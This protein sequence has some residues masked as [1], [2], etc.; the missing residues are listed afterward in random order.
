MD[1]KNSVEYQLS[2][3]IRGKKLRFE[4]PK[5]LTIIVPFGNQVN[6]GQFVSEANEIMHPMACKNNRLTLISANGVDLHKF[7][8]T[9]HRT[10][11]EI[12]DLSIFISGSSSDA[13]RDGSATLVY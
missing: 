2:G 10:R 7:Y 5:C 1:S 12:L 3:R 11:G 4:F 8:I 6:C 9:L 13:C